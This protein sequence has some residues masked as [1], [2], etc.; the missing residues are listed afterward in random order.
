MDR[1]RLK[2]PEL[3][4]NRPIRTWGTLFRP[5]GTG[6]TEPGGPRSQGDAKN[7]VGAGSPSPAETL[8]FADPGIGRTL[9]D[10][11]DAGYRVINDY[12]QQG[13]AMAQAFN[14]S[15]WGTQGQENVPPDVQQLAQRVMQYGWDFAGVWFEMWQRMA[16]NSSGWPPPP[17]GGTNGQQPPWA[18]PA[19][20]AERP[21]SHP[22][23]PPT[24]AEGPAAGPKRMVV[25]VVSERRTAAT[26]EWRPGSAASL[27]LH[28]LRPE[29]HTA[30][31]I[32]DVSIEA[33]GEHQTLTVKVVV[34][35][36]QPPGV[37]NGMI[38]DTQ[39]NLPRGTVS[40]R[41]YAEG[42]R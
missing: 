42:E 40:V 25:S 26:L 22:P 28:A 39:S 29:G 23:S 16:G 31:P 36:T 33:D 14:P 8:P 41:V 27:A 10:S 17:S 18:S 37:Y 2:R 3:E 13:Q 7:G 1:K 38:V 4:R 15:A 32:K 20:Q 12:I 35:P 5:P 19:P 11:V 34:R 6:K 30:P 21:R 24:H 9:A